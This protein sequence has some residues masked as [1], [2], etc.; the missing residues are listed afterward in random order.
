MVSRG[1]AEMSCGCGC[2]G[3]GD[4]SASPAGATPSFADLL[5]SLEPYPTMPPLQGLG[6]FALPASAG[7]LIASGLTAAVGKPGGGGGLT[8]A[9]EDSVLASVNGL[10]SG[11]MSLVAGAASNNDPFFLYLVGTPGVP[12]PRFRPVGLDTTAIRAATTGAALLSALG[13]LAQ[14]RLIDAIRT[15]LTAKLERIN[16][17]ISLPVAPRDAQTPP[18][19]EVDGES[20]DDLL[21][22]P[23]SA[24]NNTGG[25][26]GGG[27]AAAAPSDKTP[28]WLLGGAGVLLALKFLRK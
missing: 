24:S 25:S 20:F 26:T 21:Y 1:V 9:Q 3:N 15:E 12:A 10:L 28:L 13:A 18:G 27:S 6:D 5:A 14:D 23:P 7:G 17:A 2:G 4:G 19:G 8:P 22:G 16:A 11:V